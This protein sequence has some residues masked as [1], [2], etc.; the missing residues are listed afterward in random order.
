MYHLIALTF[1][2]LN[3]KDFDRLTTIPEMHLEYMALS[4][5]AAN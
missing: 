4:M 2:T 3:T 5:Q 1:E